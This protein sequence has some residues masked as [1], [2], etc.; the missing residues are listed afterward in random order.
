MNALDC[1]ARGLELNA[2]QKRVVTKLTAGD[3]IS[4]PAILMMVFFAAG[5]TSTI[6][7]GFW[8]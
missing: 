5:I 7:T 6:A 4:F 8:L 3:N 1:E 2:N